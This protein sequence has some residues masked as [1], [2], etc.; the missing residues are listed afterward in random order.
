MDKIAT[1]STSSGPFHS[2]RRRGQPSYLLVSPTSFRPVSKAGQ[3]SRGSVQG[4]HR[5]GATG[6]ESRDLV[7][8]H[9]R[10]AVALPLRQGT[11]RMR[12]T[13]LTREATN[14]PPYDSRILPYPSSSRLMSSCWECTPAFW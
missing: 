1:F 10:P 6:R 9:R 11:D 3:E 8:K 14:Q 13:A 5:E 12:S 4:D 7:R 2:G